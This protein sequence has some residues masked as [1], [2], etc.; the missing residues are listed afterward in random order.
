MTVVLTFFSM[1][2]PKLV[3]PSYVVAFGYC[4][5]DA[6]ST[7]YAIMSQE[8]NKFNNSTRSKETRAAIA[9]FDTL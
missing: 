3:T 5:A 7:G 2:Y 6:A 9:T 8:D 1:Q 4:L